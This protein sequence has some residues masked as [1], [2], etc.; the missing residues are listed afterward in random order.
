MR[1][2]PLLATLAKPMNAYQ[3]HTLQLQY[4]LFLHSHCNL[5]LAQGIQCNPLNEKLLVPRLMLVW[6]G[7]V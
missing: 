3:Y 4:L 6:V 2:V 1:T 7:Q 5:L